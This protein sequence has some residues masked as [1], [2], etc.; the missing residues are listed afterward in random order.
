MITEVKHYMTDDGSEFETYK[1]AQEYEKLY[2]KC[3]LIMNQLNQEPN[4]ECAIQ[5]NIDAIKK[6]YK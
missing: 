3:E 6:A 2:E 4:E 1:E 5:Y